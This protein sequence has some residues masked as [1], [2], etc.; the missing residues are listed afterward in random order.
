MFSY[1]SLLLYL[2]KKLLWE[3]TL[4]FFPRPVKIALRG[5]QTYRSLVETLF[6]KLLTPSS[7]PTAAL[8][9]A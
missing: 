7:V 2:V 6:W 3:Q 9:I 5:V 1:G 8:M 4:S